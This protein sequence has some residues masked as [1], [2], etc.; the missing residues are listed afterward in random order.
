MQDIYLIIAKQIINEAG[1]IIKDAAEEVYSEK[2]SNYSELIME[3]ADV[4]ILIDDGFSMMLTQIAR[5]IFEDF[6]SKEYH[7]L[8]VKYYEK[9]TKTLENLAELSYHCIKA[10]YTDKAMELFINTANQ[11]YGRHPC[12]DRLIEVGEK[13]I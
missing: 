3:L 6:E 8:A 2:F 5:R 7:E 13:L 10:G 12:V 4:N 9:L 1:R 11:I